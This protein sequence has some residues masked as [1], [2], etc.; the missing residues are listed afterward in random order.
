MPA[1][2][3]W[4]TAGLGLAA[5]LTLIALLPGTALFVDPALAQAE[6]TTTGERYAC[7]MMDFIGTKPGRCPVCGME[8]TRVTAGELSAE[9]TRRIGLQTS[10]IKRGPAVA[11]VRAYGTAEYDH[12]FTRLVIPRV[13][14][15]IV[16]RHQATAGCCEQVDADTPVIDLYSPE[17]IAAQ[18]ELQAAQKLGD[19]ALV[20]SLRERFARWNL[21][22]VAEALLAGGPVQDIVTIRSPFGGQVLLREFEMVNDALAVG[23]EVLPDTPLLRLVDPHR[24][25]VIVH[26]PETRARWIA[27]GQPALLASDDYGP[28]PQIAAAVSRVAEE[29]DPSLRA[30]E[31]RIDLTDVRSLLMPGSLVEARFRVALAPDLTPADPTDDSTWGQFPLVPKTAVLSTGV[32]NVAWKVA[33]RA[34]NGR[35]R[36][37]LAPLVLGP[38]LEDDYG[39]DLYIVRAGLVPG[40]E[41]ATQGAFLIDSQ[42]QLAGTPSLIYP[43][44]ASAPGPAHA[45]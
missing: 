3:P 9:Q 41:V 8:M 39:N 29:L 2:K 38:R 7:P 31:V 6:Q 5:G 17:V 27:V 30:R 45:H 34:R 20:N 4:M 22:D 44:G 26:V 33:E 28:L 16:A 43:R 32:R 18:G 12:R 1:W 21:T 36:F 13:A 14:G 25:V 42:A 19:A 11:T 37:E 24:L 23:R 15:R 35:L 40:D 10:V